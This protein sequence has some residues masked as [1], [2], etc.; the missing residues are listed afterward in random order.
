M[1]S[2]DSVALWKASR[3]TPTTRER[4][5]VC[6]GKAV[7]L[8]SESIM[9]KVV[10]VR[11]CPKDGREQSRKTG[12]TQSEPSFAKG[13]EAREAIEKCPLGAAIW[14]ECRRAVS[15]PGRQE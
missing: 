1:D 9:T 12:L 14:N 11:H 15:K 10:R 2:G 7:R 8:R 6:E 4:W 3:T 13:D 5:Y